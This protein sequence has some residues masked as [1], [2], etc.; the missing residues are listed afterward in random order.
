[1][2][3]AILANSNDKNSCKRWVILRHKEHSFVRYIHPANWLDK[4]PFLSKY[5]SIVG[6]VNKK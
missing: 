4:L 2:R 5:Y 1:M 3:Y 6:F